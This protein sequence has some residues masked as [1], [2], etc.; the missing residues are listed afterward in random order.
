MPVNPAS[1]RDP[2]L[3]G[4]GDDLQ[5]QRLDAPGRPVE[6]GDHLRV[7]TCS[8]RLAGAGVHPVQ[9]RVHL[10]HPREHRVG[11]VGVEVEE[12]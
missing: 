1:L 9:Q 10:G 4:S 11:A 8:Q 7:L 12:C 5:L 2:G 3:V 6:L